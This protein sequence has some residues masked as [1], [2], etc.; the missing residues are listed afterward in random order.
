MIDPKR[1]KK[2]LKILEQEDRD[3]L[4]YS[5]AISKPNLDRF[6][7]IL[8]E[9]QDSKTPENLARTVNIGGDAHCAYRLARLIQDLYGV[10]RRL[11]LVVW[12]RV[13]VP[14]RSLLSGPLNLR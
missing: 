8:V 12:A 7:S 4:V 3:L 6:I 9:G 14:A 1:A 2:L 11:R 10:R 13:R 5:G